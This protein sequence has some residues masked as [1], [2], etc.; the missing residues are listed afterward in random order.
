MRKG[1][2]AVVL[3]GRLAPMT[4]PAAATRS[5][6]GWGLATVHESAGVLDTYFPSPQLGTSTGVEAPAELLA[7]QR[8]DELRGVRTETTLVEID[9]DALPAG[10]SLALIH[11]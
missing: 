11:I 6:W 2:S 3:A 1:L 9:L 4:E 10:T 8:H 7:A 5:A